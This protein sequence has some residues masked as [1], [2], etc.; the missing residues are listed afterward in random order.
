[1]TGRPLAKY[2]DVVVAIVLA[3]ALL[4]IDPSP[5]MMLGDSQSYLMTGEG[6]P[7]FYPPDRSWLYGM[8]CHAVLGWS[9][10][11]V[12]LVVLQV[13][14]QAA[15]VVLLGRRLVTGQRIRIAFV[16]LISLDPLLVVY[17][18]FYL[19][20]CLAAL[21]FTGFVACLS[22]GRTR[23]GLG[24]LTL[25][26][27]CGIL[28][29]FL[30]IAYVPIELGAGLLMLMSA[31]LFGL[32]RRPHGETWP[33][34]QLG[35]A[36]ATPLAGALLLLA[37]NGQ[38]FRKQFEHPYFLNRLSSSFLMAA[39]A[40]ALDASDIRAGG[41]AISDAEV[42]RMHLG[43]R[44]L[45]IDQLWG[46]EPF[47]LVATIRARCA[48]TNEYDER[49]Q[50]I[51][52]AIVRHAFHRDPSAFAAVYLST[53]GDYFSIGQWRRH[54]VAEMGLG[55]M[56]PP[57]FVAWLNAQ[58]RGAPITP[59]AMQTLGPV[60]RT[61][62]AAL[63]IYPAWLALCC[64]IALAALVVGRG[65]VSRTL[66][67]TCLLACVATVAL[68]SNYVIPRYLMGGELLA[69]VVVAQAVEGWGRRR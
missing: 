9:H 22:G 42:A 67:S 41:I 13:V 24:A 47:W 59:T 4:A 33:T 66:P 5:H 1:M 44:D 20:D 30:R 28:A 54:D 29:I 64:A 39:V 49:L 69:W 53:L 23:P 43:D 60:G 12:G 38:L 68:Y 21:A 8:I 27:L 35:V 56:L 3:V 55:R 7:V 46:Q 10:R 61:Y 51:A 32:T 31:W 17:T 40:P 63:P 26:C 58:R 18:R 14:L 48:I 2:A 25:G 36:I 50:R 34:R 15:V 52:H 11:L 19:S 65:D 6:T 45:R 57:D 37:V 62:R 16:T